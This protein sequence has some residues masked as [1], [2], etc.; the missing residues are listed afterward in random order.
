MGFDM[1]NRK[2][3]YL[4]NIEVPYRVK[5]FNELSK[6]C[7]LTVLYERNISKNRDANWAK[8]CQK[9][10]KYKYLDGIKIGNESTFSYKIIGEILKGYDDVIFGCYNSYVQIFG[11][12]IMKI[13]NKPYYINLDGEPFLFSPGIKTKIK[14]TILKGAKG[15]FI[16]GINAKYNLIKAIGKVKA[17]TYYFSSLTTEQI[18]NNEFLSLNANRDDYVLVIGQF[19]DYKGL[20]I[21][22]KA[23][24][25][26]D[27]IHY[28][29]V[30]MGNRTDMFIE[31]FDLENVNN[32][33]IIPFLQTPELEKE[34][35]HAKAVV[36]PSRQ[37][38]WGL[39]VN[40]AASYGTPIV[41]TKGSGA[42]V[43]FIGDTFPQ[44]LADPGNEKSL[45]HCI[46]KCMN[47]D[48]KTYSEYLIQKSKDYN[49][50]NSVKNHL[51]GLGIKIG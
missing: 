17:T 7:D 36:L 39:V 12:L 47:S 11:I 1:T 15:Y 20:D 32:I 46:K 2:V 14:K 40:E 44:F 43:E 51:E 16:A 24:L 3:L 9:K 33:D 22:V 50:E 4:S 19:F 38:C 27:N 45:Y 26:D 41:S 25:L 10:Y 48:N 34:Y 49:I 28:K 42:A 8:S 31:R 29:F 13:L 30:G 18:K 35:L 21:A 5:F 37:E 6:Y 23:A